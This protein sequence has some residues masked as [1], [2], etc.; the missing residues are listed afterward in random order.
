[1]AKES[2]VLTPPNGEVKAKEALPPD[3]TPLPKVKLGDT[4]YYWRD[5]LVVPLVA[6]L[7]APPL[8]NG[9]WVATYYSVV[10]GMTVRTMISQSAEPELRKFTARM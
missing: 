4:V 8:R 3:A 6:V 10:S 7:I 9:D 1:M 2:A 5:D